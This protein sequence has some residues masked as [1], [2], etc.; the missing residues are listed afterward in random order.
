MNDLVPLSSLEVGTTCMID[1]IHA[2]E[3]MRRRLLDLGFSKGTLIKCLQYS[4]SGDPIAYMLRGTVIAL[5]KED[6]CQI[7]VCK[8][9]DDPWD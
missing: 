3:H 9:G 4:P 2:S 5:R 8:G 6:A 7:L 1:S